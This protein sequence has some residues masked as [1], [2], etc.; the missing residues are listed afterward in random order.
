ME[1]YQKSEIDKPGHGAAAP[2]LAVPEQVSVAMA[3]ISQNMTEGLLAHAVGAAL[4]VMCA[5]MDADVRG[6][7]R[8][9]GPVARP[10]R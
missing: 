6:A 4:Q 8:P 3:E 9:E 10:A 2:G 5:L 1:R 7:G